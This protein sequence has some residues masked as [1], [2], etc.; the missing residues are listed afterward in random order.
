MSDNTLPPTLVAMLGARMH[1]AVPRLLHRAGALNALHVD[2]AGG[3]LLSAILG[4][5]PNRFLPAGLRGLRGRFPGIPP[6]L[7]HRH[8]LFGLA[9]GIRRHRSQSEAARAAT[10]LW[11]GRAFC[12]AVVRSGALRQGAKCVFGYNSAMLELLEAAREQGIAGVV[13]QT[14]LPRALQY[15]VMEEEHRLHPRLQDPALSADP[16]WKEH[17]EREAAEWQAAAAI[18]CGSEVVAEGIR[19]LGGPAEKLRVIPYGVEPRARRT[20]PRREGPFRVLFV[21]QVGLR[22]GAHY[23]LEAARLLANEPFEFRLVGHVA[24]LPEALSGLPDGV[25]LEGFIPRDA[26]AQAFAE[27]DALCLPSLVEGSATVTYEA[28]AA[29]LPLVVT[30]EAGSIVRHGVDGLVVPARD[31]KAL[32]D[33]LRQLRET[34][35]PTMTSQATPTLAEWSL[36]A[37]GKRIAAALGDLTNPRF[38]DGAGENC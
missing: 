33:A 12:R 36:D 7:V 23:L 18:W 26:V 22:K 34:P 31:P 5:L 32:A 17:A 9:Y 3:G 28:L 27:A 1:Y 16:L 4:A 21:G 20:A 35:L 15:R 13:E 10:H 19:S 2:A 29:G 24:L 30:R 6:E 14:I 8:T 25:K 37:Y 38:A 11:G